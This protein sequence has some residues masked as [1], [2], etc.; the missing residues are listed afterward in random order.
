V[1]IIYIC[2]YIALELHKTPSPNECHCTQ[3]SHISFI[4]SSITYWQLT[5]TLFETVKPATDR[6]EIK[7][8]VWPI[9]GMGNNWIWFGFHASPLVLC[10]SSKLVQPHLKI[11][12]ENYRGPLLI[13]FQAYIGIVG[14]FKFNNIHW[15]VTMSNLLNQSVFSWFCYSHVQHHLTWYPTVST[16]SLPLSML[17]LFR[18][19]LIQ[20]FL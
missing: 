15:Q 14:R 8:K 2:I 9:R 7:E 3:S 13:Q 18:C 16:S 12:I 19:R 1:D 5:E 10:P 20:M 17:Q 6:L 4:P 11:H